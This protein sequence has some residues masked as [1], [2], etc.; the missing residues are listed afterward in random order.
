MFRGLH[1]INLDAKGRLAVPTRYRQSLKDSCDGRMIVT[2]DTEQQCLLL[3]P[4]QEWLV[5]EAKVVALPSFNSQ[6]RRIQRLLVGHA[7]EVELDSSSRLLMPPALRQY[8]DLDKKVSLVGQ[9]NKFEIWDDARW[10]ASRDAWLSQPV[11]NINDLP[12][13]L[14]QLSL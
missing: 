1:H 14:Q 13:E 5:I 2:I 11:N 7:T 9:G 8:A 3:Y 4:H 6:A 10:Q 12:D